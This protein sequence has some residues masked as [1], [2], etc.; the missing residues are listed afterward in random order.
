M[1]ATDF[2]ENAQLKLILQNI[3]ITG[4]GDAGGLRG[5]ATAG[6]L[7][8]SLHTAD[9]GES[10]TQST[11]EV[12]Y[13]GYARVAIARSTGGWTVTGNSGTN[14]AAVNFGARTD[15]AAAVTV[16][17]IGIGTAAS[18][19]GSLLWKLPLSNPSSLSI[20]QGIAPSFAAGAITISVD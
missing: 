14:A 7:Y 6:S 17:H 4:I 2:F 10:G 8:I 3:D 15:T 5:S 13:T 11:S 9:P 1:S 18:G 20:T 19:A 12:A 16:T